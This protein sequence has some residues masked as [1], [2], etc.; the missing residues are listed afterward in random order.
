MVDDGEGPGALGNMSEVILLQL[1]K[2]LEGVSPPHWGLMLQ[3]PL[4]GREGV[5]NMCSHHAF[6]LQVEVA[7]NS[8]PIMERI[9]SCPLVVTHHCL[10]DLFV[11]PHS[12]AIPMDVPV[13]K[14]PS[15]MLP[16]DP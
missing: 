8:N 10:A 2:V 1:H 3:S 11:L 16:L 4:R 9:S 15:V 14:G 13:N 7:S 5:V 6:P 12:E